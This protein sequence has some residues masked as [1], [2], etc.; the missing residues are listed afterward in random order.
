VEIVLSEGALLGAFPDVLPEETRHELR[1]GD[2]LLLYTDGITE[3]RHGDE[4]FGEERLVAA[5]AGAAGAGAEVLVETVLA[6]V[7]AFRT[8]PAEDDT[9]LLAL[10]V[11]AEDPR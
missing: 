5:A 1:A 10:H 6:A 8:A 2:T 7:E 9:A 3:S 11:L 4:L